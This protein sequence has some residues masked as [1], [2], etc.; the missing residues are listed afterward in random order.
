[1]F[2]S[3]SAS[4][5]L[6]GFIPWAQFTK[7]IILT[8]SQVAEQATALAL[9]VFSRIDGLVINH[10]ALSPVKRI[11]DSTVAEWQEAF[12]VNF[13]S[14]VSFVKA[15]LPSLRS[16]RGRIIMVSS[17]AA[18]SAYSTWGAYGSSKAAMNHLALTLKVEEPDITSIAIRPGV[19]D[20]AM[21]KD[22]REVHHTAMGAE[23]AA[24]FK[25]LHESGSLLKPEQPGNVM[26]R[27]VL[28]APSHLSG[29]F[30]T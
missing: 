25:S 23:Q 4:S 8:L 6:T 1:M 12:N 2:I 5:S 18:A 13:F 30:L 16:S 21:Q 3:I 20:T 24:K 27:L 22:I 7:F 29:M 11:S 15:A 17:G 28:D 19:V 26:C 10:G 9:K 14:A